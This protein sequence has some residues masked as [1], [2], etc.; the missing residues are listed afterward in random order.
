MDVFYIRFQ[1]FVESTTKNF[2]SFVFVFSFHFYYPK[3]KDLNTK[4]EYN[5]LVFSFF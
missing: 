3:K 1:F 5:F 4:T 2:F